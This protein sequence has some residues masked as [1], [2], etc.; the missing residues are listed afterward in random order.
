MHSAPLCTGLAHLPKSHWRWS[1]QVGCLAQSQQIG[2]V[3][4][5]STGLWL[6]RKPVSGRMPPHQLRAARRSPQVTA[7]RA[8]PSKSGEQSTEP[9]QDNNLISSAAGLL[10][11]AA[12]VG[13]HSAATLKCLP[14]S[15]GHVGMH[16]A[17]SAML[18][19]YQARTHSR[20]IQPLLLRAQV[21]AA[22]RLCAAAEP[23]PDALP[24]HV[25]PAEAGGPG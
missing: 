7:P 10:L 6:A 22:C 8:T 25:L 17:W 23:Q 16:E 1:W 2:L 14:C 21:R 15:P 13:A 19:G 9:E 5:S 18:G 12:F 4:A 20:N 3:S 11:W 24:R